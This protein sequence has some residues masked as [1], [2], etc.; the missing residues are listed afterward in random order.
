MIDISSIPMKIGTTLSQT[1]LAERLLIST[2]TIRRRGNPVEGYAGGA[3]AWRETWN[4]LPT[5]GY[6]LAEIEGRTEVVEVVAVTAADISRLKGIYIELVARRSANA[7][8]LAD[9][10]DRTVHKHD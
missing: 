2:T 5:G 10:I 8:W 6:C 9:L 3:T 1:A 7:D 4:K